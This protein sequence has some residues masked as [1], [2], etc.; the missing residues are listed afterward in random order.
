[1]VIT[2]IKETITSGIRHY[3]IFIGFMKA[4]DVL[5]VSDVPNFSSTEKDVDIAQ[6]LKLTPVKDWQRPLIEEKRERITKFFNN[7]GE[8][9]P[10]PVLI[11][12]NPEITG[13]SPIKIQP[14]L[15]G[16]QTTDFWE[17]LIDERFKSLW[18]IDGQHRIKGLG[19]QDCRQNENPIP[20]VFM[21]NTSVANA[22]YAPTDFAK[23]FAQVTTS[24]TPLYELHKEWLEYAF[25]MDK[26]SKNAWSDSMKTV[27][28]L[29][30]KPEFNE[31]NGT[32]L[33][34]YFYD[35]IVFNDNSKS[36]N[37]KLNCQ[38]FAEILFNH[39]YNEKP[40]FQAHTPDN[41]A[42]QISMAFYALGRVVVEPEKSVFLG[43]PD[44]K[45]MV[46]VKA[47][48]KGILQYILE[49]QNPVSCNHSM[50]DW[51]DLFTKLN[52]PKTDWDWSAYTNP[53]DKSWYKDSEKLASVIL[54]ETFRSLKIPDNCPDL[55]QCIVFGNN[56]Q[57]IIECKEQG[58]VYQEDVRGNRTI[59]RPGIENIRISNKSF[60][61][62]IISVVDKRTT[63]N[64]PE[65]YDSIDFKH[66]NASK[67]RNKK[68]VEVPQ[69]RP[70]NKKRPR[71]YNSGKDFTL[72]IKRTKYGGNKDS[73]EVRFII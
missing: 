54:S 22:N 30:S 53:K 49:Y 34:N 65:R 12:E 68:G 50:S 18:I 63:A 23:I 4:V 44:K 72:E 14:K 26:Y 67:K 59:N 66:E 41:L 36:D 61:A 5:K 27:I 57:L 71:D 28:E 56:F 1:M 9:M 19:D 29:C 70:K 24:S 73:F 51:T 62:E 16:G 39:Y 52:F 45:H 60:N 69:F 38:V 47:L 8:F 21:L 20:V 6:N 43:V 58:N 10:N 46:M 55:Q 11:S 7:S 37:N 42:N 35:N 33:P 3:P 15:I 17:I 31:P 13:S 40:K 25:K 2:V 48:I 32:S 64:F